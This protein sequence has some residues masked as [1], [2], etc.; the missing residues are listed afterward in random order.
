[1]DLLCSGSFEWPYLLLVEVQILGRKWVQLGGAILWLARCYLL[2]VFIH[3]FW[4]AKRPA[5]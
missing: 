1:M 2:R 3:K 4:N 5:A